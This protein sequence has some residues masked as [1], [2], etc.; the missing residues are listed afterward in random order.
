MQFTAPPG[1]PGTS[2][3]PGPQVRVAPG[4]IVYD[5]AVLAAAVALNAQAI[6]AVALSL[7]IDKNSREP[8]TASSIWVEALVTVAA[9]IL[10]VAAT[11]PSATH[12]LPSAPTRPTHRCGIDEFPLTTKHQAANIGDKADEAIPRIGNARRLGGEV[13]HPR[14]RKA[15]GMQIGQ[16]LPRISARCFRRKPPQRRR[17]KP[18][19]VELR[20]RHQ[21][22]LKRSPAAGA[23]VNATTVKVG[24]ASLL[25]A[26]IEVACPRN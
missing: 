21:M 19:R 4:P 23:V 7:L 10:R 15:A 2:Y 5:P 25:L 9:V 16:V 1:A 8:E 6:V 13:P 12:T 14:H 17:W 18:A 20:R 22:M 11:A 24:A 3:V 26:V